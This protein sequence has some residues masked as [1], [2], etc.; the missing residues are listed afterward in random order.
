MPHGPR[1]SIL[2]VQFSIFSV[3]FECSKRHARNE[4][5]PEHHHN[6]NTITGMLKLFMLAHQWWYLKLLIKVNVTYFIIVLITSF[7][8]NSYCMFC[9]KQKQL[10]ISILHQNSLNLLTSIIWPITFIFIIASSNFY[11]YENHLPS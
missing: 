6:E 11:F 1:E 3:K 7:T 9:S 4:I 2:F 10:L 8:T 5:S